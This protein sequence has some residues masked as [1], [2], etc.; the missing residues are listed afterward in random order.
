MWRCS[1]GRRQSPCTPNVPNT[2][3]TTPPTDAAHTV[4]AERQKARRCEAKKSS[5]RFPKHRHAATTTVGIDTPPYPR[6]RHRPV[7]IRLRGRIF[8]EHCPGTVMHPHN[9]R[10]RQWTAVPSDVSVERS[11]KRPHPRVVGSSGNT[12]GCGIVTPGSIRRNGRHGRAGVLRILPR[13]PHPLNTVLNTISTTSA[14]VP[15]PHP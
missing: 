3:A 5:P 15:G 1:T 13:Y 4:R 2:S 7:E 10:Y 14:T 12:T 9:Q 6:L 8:P 11:V